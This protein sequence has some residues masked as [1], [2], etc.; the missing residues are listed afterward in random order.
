MSNFSEALSL[1]K[2]PVKQ[3]IEFRLYYDADNKPLYYSME[4]SEGDYIEITKEEFAECRYDIVIKD[5][6]IKKVSGAP[7]GKL[8]PSTVGYG[9]LQNDVSIVGTEQYW[10]TK[11]YE[12]D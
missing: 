12:N 5:G 7:V 6:K 9:T 4:D 1:V 2:E 3:K 10:S 8:V 11:T